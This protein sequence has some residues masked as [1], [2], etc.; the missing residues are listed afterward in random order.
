MTRPTKSDPGARSTVPRA[1]LQALL[2]VALAFAGVAHL[3]TARQEFRAQVPSW[4]PVGDDVVVVVSGVIEIV[5]AAALLAT[6]APALS[7]WR[8]GVGLA[9]AAFFVVIFP[10]NIAQFTEQRDAFGLDSDTARGVRLLFQ[11][12]L[13][14]AA[15]WATGAWPPLR[16][17]VRARRSGPS[18]STGMF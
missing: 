15:L 1:I 16:Q 8:T 12:L 11:P 2:A 5:L 14:V 13:V 3:T 17:A 10:G 7:R 4:L 18:S 9:V 6:L